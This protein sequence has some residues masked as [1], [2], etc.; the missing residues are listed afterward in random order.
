MEQRWGTDRCSCFLSG[1][2]A[3]RRDGWLDETRWQWQ[4]HEPGVYQSAYTMTRALTAFS[5]VEKGPITT[6]SVA[7]PT[8]CSSTRTRSATARRDPAAT[9][10]E[11]AL[12]RTAFDAM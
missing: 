8:R 1:L 10:T 6:T 11:L 7:G 12:V 4:T 3:G 5:A 2:S 9:R